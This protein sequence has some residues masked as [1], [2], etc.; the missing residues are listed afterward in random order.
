M[1]HY[2]TFRNHQMFVRNSSNGKCRRY[3]SS[4]HSP[5]ILWA[6]SEMI[7]DIQRIY[8]WI[9][10]DMYNEYSTICREYVDMMW[11]H[12][13]IISQ[14]LLRYLSDT[15]GWFD[16]SRECSIDRSEFSW[17]FNERSYVSRHLSFFLA[18]VMLFNNVLNNKERHFWICS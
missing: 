14:L 18:F 2:D 17:I 9:F 7:G 11:I 4:D 13:I 1:T 6:C 8:S 12:S 10:L 15:W 16:E 3:I 5:F